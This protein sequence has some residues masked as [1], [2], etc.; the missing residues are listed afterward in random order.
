MK[1]LIKNLEHKIYVK[2][3]INCQPSNH[4]ARHLI[5]N[6]SITFGCVS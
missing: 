6:F 3:L 5:I 1:I 4:L 2:Y